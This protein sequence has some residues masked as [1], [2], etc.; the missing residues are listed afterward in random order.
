MKDISFVYDVIV[1]IDISKKIQL[2]KLVDLTRSLKTN[3]VLKKKIYKNFL[4]ILS[5]PTIRK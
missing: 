2:L 3:S 4:F 1:Y 5:K